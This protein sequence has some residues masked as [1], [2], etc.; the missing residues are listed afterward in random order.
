MA[1]TFENE[2]V[3]GS[4]L[5]DETDLQASLAEQRRID[6]MSPKWV[7]IVVFLFFFKL[8][9]KI[10]AKNYTIAEERWLRIGQYERQ[11]VDRRLRSMGIPCQMIQA[12]IQ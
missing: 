8:K 9:F 12:N 6:Q 10:G 4:E 1:E 3:Y 2:R 7:K 11:A 5:F